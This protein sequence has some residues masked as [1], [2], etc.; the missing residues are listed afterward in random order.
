[1][2]PELHDPQAFAKTGW[3][4]TAATD[5]YA[6]GMLCIEIHTGAPPF[7]TMSPGSVVHAVVQGRRPDRPTPN[8]HRSMSN[9]LWRLTQVCWKQEPSTRPPI[10]HIYE[11]LRHGSGAGPKTYVHIDCE[12]KTIR[13]TGMAIPLDMPSSL[14]LSQY[15]RQDV[16][17]S[18]LSKSSDGNFAHTGV[19]DTSPKSGWS[20]LAVSCVNSVRRLWRQVRGTRRG[21]DWHCCVIC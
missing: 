3:E 5:V 19:V 4:R 20:F 11:E 9:D 1:M 18:R 2:A 8:H 7:S 21:D 17:E 10:S 16:P 14:N 13:P 6:F 15:F 12:Y